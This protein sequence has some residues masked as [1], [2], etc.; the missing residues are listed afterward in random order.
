LIEPCARFDN[1]RNERPF[2]GNPRI[3][4]RVRLECD[5]AQA[6]RPIEED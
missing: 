1:G 5:P 2:H 3:S 4:R 6:G